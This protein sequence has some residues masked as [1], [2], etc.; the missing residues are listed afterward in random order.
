MKEKTLNKTTL[1]PVIFSD[2]LTNWDTAIVDLYRNNG[3]FASYNVRVRNC[4]LHYNDACNEYYIR[5]KGITFG[6]ND[7]YNLVK[8]R[9]LA[10]EE[11]KQI[12]QMPK[13]RIERI[14]PMDLSTLGII[15]F[16]SI[17][18]TALILFYYKK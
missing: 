13:D 16:I 5:Y 14:P 17:L 7:V 1:L 2:L 11:V 10:N 18:I 8:D 9:L 6:M 15:I 4:S 12:P 3:T